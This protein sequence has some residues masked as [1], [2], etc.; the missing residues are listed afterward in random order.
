KVGTPTLRVRLVLVVMKVRQYTNSCITR[1]KLKITVVSSPATDMGRITRTNAWKRD[2]PSII[3]A[4]STSLG[5]TLKK[6]WRSQ[7]QKG[8]VKLGDTSTSAHSLSVRPR[9]GTIPERGVKE[10]VRGALEVS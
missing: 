7:V 4:S 9:L 6:P 10:S 8:T 5:M 3:A 1:V 2:S